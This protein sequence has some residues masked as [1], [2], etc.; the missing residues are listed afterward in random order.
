MVNLARIAFVV[1]VACGS[2]AVG[3]MAWAQEGEPQ[4]APTPVTTRVPPGIITVVP[5]QTVVVPVQSA[6]GAETESA[7]SSLGQEGSG[8]NLFTGVR[9]GLIGSGIGFG[10][11]L[12][13]AVAVSAVRRGLRRRQQ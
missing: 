2:A 13:L 12:V 1:L 5:E 11:V 6:A 8:G 4:A 3:G 9:G 7:D 10:A